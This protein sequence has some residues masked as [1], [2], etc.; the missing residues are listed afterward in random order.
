LT[1]HTADN[2]EHTSRRIESV[3]VPIDFSDGSRQALRYAAEWTQLYNAKLKVVH[4]IEDLTEPGFYLEE[5]LSVSDLRPLIEERAIQDLERFVRDVLG[6]TEGI[7]LQAFAGHTPQGILWYAA[8]TDVDLIVMFTYG[9]TGIGRLLAG[10][11]A[12]RVM[13]QAPCPVLTL[14]PSP[15]PASEPATLE[16][17]EMTA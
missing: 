15:E 14:R 3:L 9:M 13:R 2:G 10:S 4:V 7:Q 16:G 6:S 12:E 5:V 11:I 8:E 1:V 17:E